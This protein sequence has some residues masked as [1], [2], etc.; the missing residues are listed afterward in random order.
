MTHHRRSGFIPCIVM[1]VLYAF[2]VYAES[3]PQKAALEQIEQLTQKATSAIEG[4][5]YKRGLNDLMEALA[6]AD[7]VR[8][9]AHAGIA[10]VYMLSGVAAV[11]GDNDTY[12]GL[13]YLVRALRLDG[14]VAIPEQL[15][16]PQLDHIYKKAH[17]AVKSLKTPQAITFAK[18]QADGAVEVETETAS[19]VQGISHIPVDEAKRGYA[20]P[21]RVLIGSDVRAQKV[22]LH[23]RPA[24]TVK[25]VEVA[26]E[27]TRATYRGAI[28]ANATQGRYVHYYIEARDPRG[29]TTATN[30]SPVSP[31]VVIVK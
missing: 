3:A 26:L 16:S 30:G 2:P 20:I 28:P 21:L 15:A 11:A 7:R 27:R 18:Q 4:Y 24:G 29:K 22:Y 12:R 13:Y 19:D 10:K 31:H 8:L 5:N 6:I 9:S 25:F 14:N 23:F 1:F 17:A